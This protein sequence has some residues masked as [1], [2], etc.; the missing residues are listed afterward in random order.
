[1][2]YSYTQ[3]LLL[4]LQRTKAPDAGLKVTLL[5]RN[6]AGRRRATGI[7]PLAQQGVALLKQIHRPATFL[8]A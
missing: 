8:P 7:S 4:S 3:Q 2:T 1:M 6:R 5:D